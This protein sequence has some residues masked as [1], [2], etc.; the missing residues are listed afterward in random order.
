VLLRS[1]FFLRIPLLHTKRFGLTGHLSDLYSATG[2]C[3][4][5]LGFIKYGLFLILQ[6]VAGPL[7]VMA[8]KPGHRNSTKHRGYTRNQA[9]FWCITGNFSSKRSKQNE[10]GLEGRVCCRELRSQGGPLGSESRQGGCEHDSRSQR[11]SLRT[12][13]ISA[14]PYVTYIS[15]RGGCPTSAQCG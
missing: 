15:R 13:G 10:P 12:G 3:N 6:Q 11:E 14:A 2:C 5:T 9:G 7:M 8:L 4:I 1:L